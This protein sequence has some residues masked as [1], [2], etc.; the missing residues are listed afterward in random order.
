MGYYRDTGHSAI[1]STD[2]VLGGGGLNRDITEAEVD[3]SQKSVLT[4][5]PLQGVISL[6]FSPFAARWVVANLWGGFGLTYIENTTKADLGD[7]ADQADVKPYLNSG[8][9]REQVIGAS[10]SFDISALSPRDAY[11]LRVYGIESIY[12]TP[13]FQT[14]A[15][16]KN[17]VGIYDRSMMGLMFTFET[18]R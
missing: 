6:G 18:R 12:L 11:S 3:H 4:I 16:R 15:T 7:D 13:Y 9:N 5:V 17:K 2:L 10:L 8:W 14:V 1:R